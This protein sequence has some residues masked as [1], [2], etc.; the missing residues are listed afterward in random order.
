MNVGLI[1]K[2]SVFGVSLGHVFNNM[3]LKLFVSCFYSG[4]KCRAVISE[5]RIVY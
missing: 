2:K 3:I 5:D 1:K 4:L